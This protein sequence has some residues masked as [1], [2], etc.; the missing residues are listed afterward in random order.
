MNHHKENKQLYGGVTW[1]AMEFKSTV[2][3]SGQ[4]IT[5]LDNTITET[6]CLVYIYIYIRRC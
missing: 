3:L 2:A 4:H 6:V 5:K 1:F